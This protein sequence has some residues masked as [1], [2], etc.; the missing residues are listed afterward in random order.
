MSTHEIMET[1]Y[2]RMSIDEIHDRLLQVSDAIGDIKNQINRAKAIK[3][4][5]GES[6]DHEWFLKANYALRKYGVAHQKLQFEL[7]KK[8]KEEKLKMHQQLHASIP[9]QFIQAAKT[10]LP[11]EQYELILGVAQARAGEAQKLNN[12]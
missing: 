11:K 2:S 5:T 9:E 1:D 4:E 10:M 12:R 6:A 3:E 8:K 7:S